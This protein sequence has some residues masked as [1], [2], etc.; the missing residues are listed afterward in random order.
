MYRSRKARYLLVLGLLI[1]VILPL[2]SQIASA[3]TV[4][5]DLQTPAQQDVVPL[6]VDIMQFMFTPATV[7][8]PVG[9][10]INWTNHD[11]I[12]HSVTEG[13]PDRLP[14]FDSGFF[15]Q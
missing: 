14:A 13:S 8:A 11:A 12:E 2:A 3:T 1:I 15:V 9:T 5:E 4:A 10:T 7:E 6:A